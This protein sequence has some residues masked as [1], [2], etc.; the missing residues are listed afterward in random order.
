MTTTVLAMTTVVGAAVTVD[1]KLPD[2]KDEVRTTMLVPTM[3]VVGVALIVSSV[4][5][6]T[7]TLTSKVE[8]VLELK[9]TSTP[10]AVAVL[11]ENVVW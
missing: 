1:T 9:V 8:R 5:V 2:S 6:V 7:S 10:S 3:S 4:V 11:R